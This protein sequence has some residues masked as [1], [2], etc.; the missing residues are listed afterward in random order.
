MSP[1]LDHRLFH[2]NQGLDD[3]QLGALLSVAEG[4]RSMR[5]SQALPGLLKGA[6]IALVCEESDGDS[7][8]EHAATELGAR[9]ARIRASDA[10]L[11]DPAD[12]QATAKVF[13]RL[14][15]AVECQGLATCVVEQLEAHAGI[16]VYNGIGLPGHP[17]VRELWPLVHDDQAVP[18][19]CG[20]H[21][22]REAV[23]QSI[24]L[25]T[26]R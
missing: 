8:F 9:V 16:V 2:D 18:G 1:L 24:L 22:C 7:V 25:S 23:I 11:S 4:L 17:V 12:L 13:G 5:S 15:D 20:D 3:Q 19:G 6:N 10:G 14:Y 21:A 26:L